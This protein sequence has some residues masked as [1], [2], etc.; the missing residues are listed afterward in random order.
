MHGA[1]AEFEVWVGDGRRLVLDNKDLAAEVLLNVPCTATGTGRRRPDVLRKAIPPLA[2]THDASGAGDG[3]RG[4]RVREGAGQSLN[5][6][7]ANDAAELP[8]LLKVQFELAEHAARY[9]L[10][11]PDAA[12]QKGGGVLVYRASSLLEAESEDQARR[13]LELH[14]DLAGAGR[15]LLEAAPVAARKVPGFEDA[16]TLGGSLRVVPESPEPTLD[17]AG[18]FYVARFTRAA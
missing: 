10:R 8:G 6:S 3:G 4:R 7:A 11:P 15:P 9:L 14:A 17:N 18:V 2:L 13:L 1:T 12:L 5:E 16:L